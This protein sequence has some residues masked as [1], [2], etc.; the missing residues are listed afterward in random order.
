MASSCRYMK[1]CDLLIIQSMCSVFAKCVT[2]QTSKPIVED[3]LAFAR[4]MSQYLLREDVFLTLSHLLRTSQMVLDQG[5][6][7][8]TRELFKSKR[9]QFIR[10]SNG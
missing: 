3:L 10:T 6:L 9:D 7:D 8:D 2:D 1:Y 4:G 5:T